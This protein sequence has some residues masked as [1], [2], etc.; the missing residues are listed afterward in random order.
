MLIVPGPV[1]LQSTAVLVVPLTVAVN[2]CVPPRGTVGAAGV[3]VTFTTGA[4]MVMVALDDLL[5]SSTE[6]AV[7][8]TVGGLGTASGAV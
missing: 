2:C 6:V 1:R 7:S 3:R 8:V 4:V 5:L